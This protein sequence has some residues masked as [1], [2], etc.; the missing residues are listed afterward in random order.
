MR[1]LLFMAFA[2]LGHTSTP[3]APCEP[4]VLL[5]V[6]LSPDGT[7][8]EVSFSI[9]A[10][11][12]LVT[13][14]KT[15]PVKRAGLPPPPP[16]P[17]PPPTPPAPM[18]PAKADPAKALVRIQFGNAGCTATVIGPRR[19]DGKWDLL[20]AA[21]CISG[22]GAKGTGKLLDGRSVNLVA[23]VRAEEPD[24]CWLCTVEP[25]DS[26][27]FAELAREVPAA[28]V[29]IW[30]AG[31]GVDRPGN[32]EVGVTVGESTGGQLEMRLSVSSG[33]SG[34]GIFREDTGEL[35]AAVC[36]TSARGAVARVWGGSSVV[37]RRLRPVLTSGDWSPMEIPVYP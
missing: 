1:T 34:G 3:A 10:D 22:P 16:P 18:P 4:E 36:C 8:A 9:L 2:A 7:T 20:T 14:R 30:H 11:G 32:R 13:V 26:L 17:P 35:I 29:P 21:H 15:V 5:A 19:S 24:L 28:G 6:K 37:A 33:D 23:G 12:E 25:H 27:P 31:Y